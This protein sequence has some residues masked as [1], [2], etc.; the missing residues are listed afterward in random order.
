M[1][2]E[3]MVIDG[4]HE[5]LRCSQRSKAG[6][7]SLCGRRAV[8][9]RRVSGELGLALVCASHLRV[10]DTPLPDVLPGRVVHVVGDVLLAGV[11]DRAQVA[12]CEGAAHVAAAIA[13]AAGR[14]ICWRVWSQAADLRLWT[15]PGAPPAGPG[16]GQ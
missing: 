9:I 5:L 12:Q 7:A 13:A 6:G 10:G 8:G 3:R 14:F 16:G 2:I 15:P 1:T 4:A 11:S